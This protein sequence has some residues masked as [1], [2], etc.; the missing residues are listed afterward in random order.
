MKCVPPKLWNIGKDNK[1]IKAII[2]EAKNLLTAFQDQVMS[3]LKSKQVSSESRTE[4]QDNLHKKAG[5]YHLLSQ[6]SF[7]LGLSRNGHGET[8]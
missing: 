1:K 8:Q 6:S 5:D 3:F 2:E 7:L 4:K